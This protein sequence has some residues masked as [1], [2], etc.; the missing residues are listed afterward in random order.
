MDLRPALPSSS[1]HKSV[2]GLNGFIKRSIDVGVS[3]VLL[4]VL[5]PVFLI[6]AMAVRLADGGPALYRQLR[7]GLRGRRFIIIKFRTMQEDA[8]RD[9]GPIWSVPGDPRCTWIGRYLRRFNL[10]ELPQLWNVFRGDMSLVGPR[11]ERPEFVREFRNEYRNYEIRLM[12]R[13]GLT[14]YAQIHGWHGS[15]SLEDR[16]RHDTHYVRKW[17]L[18]M[19]L[20]VLVMTLLWGWS[21]RTRNGL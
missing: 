5:A 2:S 18:R 14:G 3:G 20:Y 19:D 6:I 1:P 10:D 7:M 12:V 21:D 13:A 9:V 17:S 16:L 4:M 8:E 11:P 15:T